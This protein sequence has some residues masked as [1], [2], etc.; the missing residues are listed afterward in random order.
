MQ[1]KF[2]VQTKF[3]YRT[4]AGLLQLLPSLESVEPPRDVQGTLEAAHLLCLY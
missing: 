4:Y 1:Y 3:S 2:A